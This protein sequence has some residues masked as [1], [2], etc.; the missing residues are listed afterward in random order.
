LHDDLVGGVAGTG[1]KERRAVFG[2]PN[3]M[4]FYGT[5]NEKK[6]ATHWQS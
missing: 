5:M 1:C 4:L 3:R 6:A 2:V